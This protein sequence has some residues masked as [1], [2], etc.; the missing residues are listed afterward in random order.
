MSDI[1]L[2][3]MTFNIHK[4]G[5]LYPSAVVVTTPTPDGWALFADDGLE[6]W[7][8]YYQSASV[9]MM[10]AA[11]LLR[12][13]EVNG[14]SFISDEEEFQPLAEAFLDREVK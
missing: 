14:G 2:Q 4:V 10:R 7:S 13:Y 6:T 3:G 12:C 1:E 8:E 9:A 11:A 5:H